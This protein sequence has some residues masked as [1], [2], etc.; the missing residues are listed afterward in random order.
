MIRTVGS[1]V[2][3]DVRG[4]RARRR[5]ETVFPVDSGHG[6]AG[7]GAAGRRGGQCAVALYLTFH[8]RAGPLRSTARTLR[9]LSL[10]D[11][12]CMS[13]N[14]PARGINW[15]VRPIMHHFFS[16]T[17]SRAHDRACRISTSSAPILILINTRA[18]DSELRHKAPMM[19]VM[20]QEF[21]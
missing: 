11:C 1:M 18:T 21:A 16:L 14:C 12:A 17:A 20:E 6:G 2:I 13:R 9:C 4:C 19:V 7:A 8:L 3:N 5:V 10:T 15:H